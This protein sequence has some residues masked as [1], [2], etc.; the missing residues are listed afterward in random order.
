MSCLLPFQ[1]LT[2]SGWKQPDELREQADMVL[3]YNKARGF[4][5][6][7]VRQVLV[8]S[9]NFTF[10]MYNNSVFSLAVCEGKA[11]HLNEAYGRAQEPSFRNKCTVVETEEYNPDPIL[12]YKGTVADAE[13]LQMLALR[14]GQP[15][16]VAHG[17]PGQARFRTLDSPFVAL[18]PVDHAVSSASSAVAVSCYENEATHFVARLAALDESGYKTSCVVI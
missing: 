17:E 5:Y 6:Q 16:V 4:E 10:F 15:A 2:F 18:G 11:V 8:Y 3:C 14:E 9:S 13:E 1:V 7:I 12:E